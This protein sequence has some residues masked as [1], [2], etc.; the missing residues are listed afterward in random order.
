MSCNSMGWDSCRHA[1]LRH[2]RNST[3]R[4]R[5]HGA[6]A[7]VATVATCQTASRIPS[8][9]RHGPRHESRP[10]FTRHTWK[11]AAAPHSRST[12]STRDTW[13]SSESPRSTL[14]SLHFILHTVH[15]TFHTRH[16]T[17]F[18]PHST[19]HAPHFILD[20]THSTLFTPHSTL[21]AP[22]FILDPAHSTLYTPHSPLYT[23]HPTLYTLHVTPHTPPTRYLRD[24]NPIIHFLVGAILGIL[25]TPKHQFLQP[26]SRPVAVGSWMALEIRIGSIAWTSRSAANFGVESILRMAN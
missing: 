5:S 20:P 15:L 4:I 23:W 6:T 19:L 21:H 8:W 14:D 16:S 3:A 22:H 26:S 13:H 11:W 12:L 24:S 25:Q 1:F 2:F 9:G 10:D 18:S 7:T 17:L